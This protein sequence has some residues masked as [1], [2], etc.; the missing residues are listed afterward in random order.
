[1]AQQNFPGVYSRV[2]DQSFL[3]TVTSRFTCGLI[4]VA[5]KG[6]FDVGQHQS[7]ILPANMDAPSQGAF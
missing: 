1:M 7:K 6:P 4:G 2:I 5:E 3:P